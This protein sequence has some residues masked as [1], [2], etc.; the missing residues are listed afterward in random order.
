MVNSPKDPDFW[1]VFDLIE[2]GKLID[3]Y[4]GIDH[5]VYFVAAAPGHQDH[6][7]FIVF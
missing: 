1:R 5:F 3:K 2:A 4:P 6:F 7:H